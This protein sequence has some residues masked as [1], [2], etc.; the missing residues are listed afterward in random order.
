ML[1]FMIR[2]YSLTPQ[3]IDIM[4]TPESE[5]FLLAQWD[6]GI[7]GMCWAEKLAE[8]GKAIKILY[9]GYPIRFISTALHVLPLLNEVGIKPDEYGL[10]IIGVDSD[11][12]Y[13]M[14][15]NWVGKLNLKLE[16]ISV[17]RPDTVLTIDAWDLS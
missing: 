10:L 9:A 2:V 17:C 5:K 12:K 1:G 7:I 13:A 16:K 14:N 6:A 11:E 3:Q 15:S 8:E 4:K